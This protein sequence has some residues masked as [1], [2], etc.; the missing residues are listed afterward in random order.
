MRKQNKVA[1]NTEQEGNGEEDDGYASKEFPS[2]TGSGG[3]D[4]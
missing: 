1:V 4:T 2:G 3:N